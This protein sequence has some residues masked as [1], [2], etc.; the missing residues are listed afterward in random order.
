M[1]PSSL[2]I[3]PQNLSP[4]LFSLFS[5]SLLWRRSKPR[6]SSTMRRSAS[7]CWAGDDTWPFTDDEA[8]IHISFQPPRDERR[9]RTRNLTIK[10]SLLHY[11]PPWWHC[12]RGSGMSASWGR[13]C[14]WPGRWP[15]G[16]PPCRWGRS[17][18]GWGAWCPWAEEQAPTEPQHQQ[19][20]AQDQGQGRGPRHGR[21]CAAR[22]GR[23]GSRGSCT[24]FSWWDKIGVNSVNFLSDYTVNRILWKFNPCH[25]FG[26]RTC[27]KK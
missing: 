25:L 12:R 18:R 14:W 4:S 9:R 27:H 17:G 10:I 20:P 1:F 23:R 3:N 13:A 15:W 6:A 19:E 21:H 26:C 22:S 2:T 24:T 7:C 11:T 5:A 16:W 8:V